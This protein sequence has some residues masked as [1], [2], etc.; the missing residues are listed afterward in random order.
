MARRR[1]G[2][3]VNGCSSRALVGISRNRRSICY[4]DILSVLSVWCH[5]VTHFSG[6]THRMN[7]QQI[8]TF[9]FFMR[10]FH[11]SNR[12]LG[13]CCMGSHP[14]LKMNLSYLKHDVQY[15]DPDALLYQTDLLFQEEFIKQ[16]MNCSFSFKFGPNNLIPELECV[17]HLVV[18]HLHLFNVDNDMPAECSYDNIFPLLRKT[19]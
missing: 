5:G 4:H 14:F 15:D 10:G 12:V 16:T 17:L 3:R 7:L 13:W 11:E 18:Y 8:Y 2:L 19:L 9:F 6:L 1:R